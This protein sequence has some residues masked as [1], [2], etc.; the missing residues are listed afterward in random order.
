MEIE[1]FFEVGGSESEIKKKKKRRISWS[2]FKTYQKCP[3][4][5]QLKYRDGNYVPSD[6]IHTIFGSA[7]HEAIQKYLRVLYH[8]SVKEAEQ[9][10]L[11][12]ILVN[13]MKDEFR[14]AKQ[15]LRE[16]E[17]IDEEDPLP[18]SY[19]EMKLFLMDGKKIL[20]S[21]LSNRTDYFNTHETELVGIE[22]EVQHNIV[23]DVDYVGYLDVVLR[24]KETGKY[25]IIDL[26]T[27][28]SGWDKWK[29][30]DKM[31]VNQ[32]VS[33]KS[34]YADM[35]DTDPKNIDIEYIILKRKLKETSYFR[36]SRIQTFSP[37]NGSI[38]QS[39]VREQIETFVDEAYNPDGSRKPGE[40]EKKPGK[41]KCCFCPFSKQ[42][43][44]DYPVCDQDGVEFGVD[45]DDKYPPGMKG[46]VD[47]KYIRD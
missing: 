36:Q 6:S 37:A 26:K 3:H 46:Y 38:T 29:K 28:K 32:L 7:V 33:Y 14:K 44:G 31:R 10:D 17:F 1:N 5:W 23:E 12:K 25:K 4:Q 40:F 13:K 45:E 30:K 41:F 42:F 39:T 8:R 22:L 24:E 19:P 18:A 9:L 20:K 34:Y 43:N 16:S 35:L 15:T 47:D 11:E 27:S 21:F 2:Q